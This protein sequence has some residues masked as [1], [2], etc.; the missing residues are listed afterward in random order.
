[1]HAIQDYQ[2]CRWSAYAFQEDDAVPFTSEDVEI[3]GPLLGNASFTY[4][5]LR[6][7]KEK[8]KAHLI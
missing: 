1:M 4:E 6:L 3:L 5:N 7:L 8:K 2:R